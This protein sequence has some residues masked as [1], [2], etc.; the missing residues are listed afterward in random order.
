MTA[1]S[2]PYCSA[3]TEVEKVARR[4]SDTGRAF[5]DH[6]SEVFIRF[7][8]FLIKPRCYPRSSF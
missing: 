6:D 4:V 8:I 3:S 5:L 1:S 7:N 2:Q